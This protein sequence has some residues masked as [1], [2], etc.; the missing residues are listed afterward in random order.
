MTSI[1]LVV[2][3]TNQSQPQAEDFECSWFYS[4]GKRSTDSS[5]TAKYQGAIIEDSGCGHILLETNKL[6]SEHCPFQWWRQEF[7]VLQ[8]ST[9][10]R[11][12]STLSCYSNIAD[13]S[14][15]P[16]PRKVPC[17]A[18]NTSISIG[19]LNFIRM[20]FKLLHNWI[21]LNK[22]RMEAAPTCFPR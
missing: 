19:I 14:T 16:S 1:Y 10:G 9:T 8:V 6:I 7:T 5:G 3:A 15:R 20:E 2:S 11:S 17:V 13:V 22:I 12:G 21:E 4:K 18:I